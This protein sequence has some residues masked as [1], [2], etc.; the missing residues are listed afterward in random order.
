MTTGELNIEFPNNKFN[1]FDVDNY[2]KNKK[3][4]KASKKNK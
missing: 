3:W 2:C 4:Y 1:T